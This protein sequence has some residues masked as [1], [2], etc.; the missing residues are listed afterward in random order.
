M[1]R[2]SRWFGGSFCVIFLLAI[3]FQGEALGTEMVGNSDMGEP[4]RI[5]QGTLQTAAWP[6]QL[7]RYDSHSGG[8]KQ[9]QGSVD[10]TAD[11]GH[12]SPGNRVRIDRDT[13]QSMVST[14][15]GIPLIDSDSSRREKRGVIGAGLGFVGAGFIL[16][17]L[18]ELVS[19][20]VGRYPGIKLEIQAEKARIGMLNRERE[21]IGEK[22][23]ATKVTQGLGGTGKA[24]MDRE[25]EAKE[26][27]I[28]A[29]EFEIR[30]LN[31]EK[32]FLG[33]RFYINQEIEA[34]RTRLGM[35]GQYKG[36]VNGDRVREG[37]IA[38]GDGVY[39]EREVDSTPVSG[40]APRADGELGSASEM[41][42]GNSPPSSSELI[43]RP[44]IDQE[45]SIGEARIRMLD[46]NGKITEYIK[47]IDQGID[48]RMEIIEILRRDIKKIRD[49][50]I[51]WLG[52]T[53]QGDREDNRIRE[54]MENRK[55]RLDWE[56]A[57]AEGDLRNAEAVQ[58]RWNVIKFIFEVIG[59]IP[60][61]A[62][63]P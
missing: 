26:R 17:Q 32:D 42:I 60:P 10:N 50:E 44:D 53:V 57:Q 48:S 18:Y 56:V 38:Q 55:I 41:I 43:E 3:P 49:G 29:R 61:T 6:E 54:D 37:V 5:Q 62:M 40:D 4:G 11:V 25:I 14:R 24:D 63:I 52:K 51:E 35:L 30:D 1:N 15:E 45:I 33:K 47:Y 22:T 36:E 20:E 16:Y 34:L 2:G 19:N 13:N 8:E 58:S 27:E 39:Q 46:D 7:D 9:G 12:G 28:L 21:S 23:E 59:S 31:R